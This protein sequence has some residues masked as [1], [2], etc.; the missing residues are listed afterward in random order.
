[1]VFI[2]R[3]LKFT[4]LF[5]SKGDVSIRVA[6]LVTLIQYDIIPLV[7][8]QG[9]TIQSYSLIACD[10]HSI[11]LHHPIDQ[12]CLCKQV[13]IPLYQYKGSYHLRLLKGILQSSIKSLPTLAL[14]S[15][16]TNINYSYIK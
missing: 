3:V 5:T 11:T 10:H 15:K 7:P 1:M 8:Q 13:V 9:V 16:Y 6:D 4:D 12:G 2:N 14:V